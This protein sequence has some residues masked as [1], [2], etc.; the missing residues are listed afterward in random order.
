MRWNRVL[1]NRASLGAMH[2][3]SGNGSYNCDRVRTGN[4]SGEN[5]VG[6]E[7]KKRTIDTTTDIYTQLG[8]PSRLNCWTLCRGVGRSWKMGG[9]T[10]WTKSRGGGQIGQEGLF[11][12]IS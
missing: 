4:L 10:N 1:E 5:G 8:S 11:P 7:M 2:L 9:G 12:D 6:R 3:T